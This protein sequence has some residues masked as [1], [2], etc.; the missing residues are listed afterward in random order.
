[1]EIIRKLQMNWIAGE[2]PESHYGGQQN[3]LVS[4]SGVEG[5]L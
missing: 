5:V 2:S 1:M 3:F 4:K